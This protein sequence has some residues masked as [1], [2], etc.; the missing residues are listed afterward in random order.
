M[1]CGNLIDVYGT[2]EAWSYVA[3]VVEVIE[4]KAKVSTNILLMSFSN[5]HYEF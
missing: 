5:V 2:K 3:E 1:N 4:T